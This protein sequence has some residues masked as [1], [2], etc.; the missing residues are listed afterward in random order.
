MRDI[1]H[2]LLLLLRGRMGRGVSWG[3]VKGRSIIAELRRVV[4]RVRISIH[5]ILIILVLS[6]LLNLLLVI[7]TFLFAALFLA[8]LLLEGVGTVQGVDELVPPVIIELYNRSLGRGKLAAHD[9]VEDPSSDM[10]DRVAG[11]NPVLLLQGNGLLAA[12]PELGELALL[13]AHELQF[14]VGDELHLLAP[15]LHVDDE[16]VVVL[17]R[18]LGLAGLRR[19]VGVLGVIENDLIPGDTGISLGGTTQ[20]DPVTVTHATVVLVLCACLGTGL[21]LVEFL[22]LRRGVDP[23]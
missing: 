23:V 21:A 10:R 20:C 2:G 17:V 6:L 18:G 12:T 8:S 16:L 15:L 22:V 5:I 11:C 14:G 9:R 13:L 4:L 19:E 7:A 1:P 3:I